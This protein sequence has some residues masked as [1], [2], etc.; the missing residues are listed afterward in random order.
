MADVFNLSTKYSANKSSFTHKN[1]NF[2]KIF[3][4]IAALFLSSCQPNLVTKYYQGTPDA[5]K[6]PHYDTTQSG[7]QIYSSI[8]VTKDIEA[9]VRKSYVPIG[10]FS[11][12][13][14]SNQISEVQLREQAMLIGAHVVL[15][16]TKYKDTISGAM[17]LV[18][19]NTTTT[20]SSGKAT[21]Y[22][23]GGVVNVYGSGTTTT[24]GT[25]TMVMPYS[26]N[27]SDYQAVFLAKKF[28]RFGANV[29]PLD[30]QTRQRLQS[31]AGVI[32]HLTIEGS[33]AYSADILDGDVLLSIENESIQ[34]P[35]HFIQVLDKCADGQTLAIKINR[36]GKVIQKNVT[37][38][39]W[40]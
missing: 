40:N 17:P 11:F 32:I 5:R 30:T 36:N 24:Y 28:S 34:G 31:N 26:I 4:F 18:L 33:P 16:S 1:I 19:P 22:G 37:L 9:L 29:I 38:R 8:D 3:L 20:Y 23:N 35:E 39:S 14:P 21:A 13:G 15:F 27:R 2:M 12:F 7:V 6:L 25:Q 10:G